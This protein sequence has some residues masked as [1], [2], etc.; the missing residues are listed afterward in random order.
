MGCSTRLFKPAHSLLQRRTLRD[1]HHGGPDKASI[2]GVT[3]L[4]DCD[5][6][7]GRHVIPGN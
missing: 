4:N 1:H 7:I 5:H 3:P 6:C 2:K